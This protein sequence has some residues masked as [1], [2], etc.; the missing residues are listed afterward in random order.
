MIVGIFP[1][2]LINGGQ[3]R[4]LEQSHPSVIIR[5]WKRKRP[6]SHCELLVGGGSA[7]RAPEPGVKVNNQVKKRSPQVLLIIGPHMVSASTTCL[8][9]PLPVG[10]QSS[11]IT[12]ISSIL[13]HLEHSTNSAKT[14]FPPCRG[15][16][17][18]AWAWAGCP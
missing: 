10:S 1:G 8:N 9:I 14:A 11:C 7:W 15:S 6:L 2:S 18:S 3:T 17:S 12:C 16:S 4:S 5:A 13:L